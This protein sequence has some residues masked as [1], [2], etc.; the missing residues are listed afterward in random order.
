MEQWRDIEGFDGLYQVS[1]Q[2]R[3]KSLKYGKEKILKGVKSCNGYL[4]VGLCKDGKEVRK[5]IHRL[6]A[7][8]FLPN[9]QNLPQV[10]HKDEDKTN[11]CVENLEW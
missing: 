9:P 2:G 10:N 1:N 5:Y 4:T 8:A 6:V 11:N 3:V 7:E